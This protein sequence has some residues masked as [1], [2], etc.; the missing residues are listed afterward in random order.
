MAERT[1]REDLFYR[2]NV[3]PITVPPLRERIEDIPVLVWAFIDEFSKAFGKKIESVSKEDL[4]FPPA[5][6]VARQR[7][8]ASQRHRASHHRCDRAAPDSGLPAARR[9]GAS[10]GAHAG[11]RRGSSHPT[12]PEQRR[13]AR[14]RARRPAELL[15]DEADDSRQPDGEAR[16][17]RAREPE[18]RLAIRPGA[19][20]DAVSRAGGARGGRPPRPSIISAAA[21]ALAT[22]SAAAT[23]AVA[24]NPATKASATARRTAV[25]SDAVALGGAWAA[26]SFDRSA[27]RAST[28]ARR[29]PTARQSAIQL[30][31]EDL[32]QKQAHQG[33]R[34]QSRGARDGV[35]D[36]R[37]DPSAVAP[38]RNSSPSWSAGRHSSPSR[39]PARPW[40]ERM[41][42][43]SSAKR[44]RASRAKPAAAIEWSDDQRETRT[45]SVHQP[46]GPARE[47]EHDQDEG[48]QGRA[49]RGRRVIVA[50]G[51]G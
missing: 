42:P 17:F 47:K 27:S 22:A 5:L 3:F 24:R 21:T 13:L 35:V 32:H 33:D 23:Q 39:P 34:E 51:S 18:F 50:P 44:G 41:S 37:G 15:G 43:S 4:G 45:A 6:L 48:K 19:V 10:R 36:P 49:R 7:A 2:L 40:L 46:A 14:A 26:P 28:D 30:A 29:K 25:R 9:T 31:I 16:G 20:Y 11:G 1:F 8:R 12:D 38:R